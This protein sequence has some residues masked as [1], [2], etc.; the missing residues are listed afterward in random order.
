MKRTGTRAHWGLFGLALI[1]LLL[2]G[3][4][5]ASDLDWSMTYRLW[6]CPSFRNV[7]CPA[8]N[9]HLEL[10]ADEAQSDVLVVYDEAH[11][12]KSAV[13]RRAF[14][15]NQNLERIQA[16]RKPRFVTEAAAHGLKPIP[17]IVAGPDAR[18]KIP[19]HGLAVL[20]TERRHEFML[21]SD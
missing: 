19:A 8:A 18:E 4:R 16:G 11:E 2:N 1:A 15:V 6:N 13:R 3:C 17:V 7:R 21:F 12:K 10:F 14:F 5:S 9:L 20:M